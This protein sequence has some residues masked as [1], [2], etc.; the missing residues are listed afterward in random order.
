MAVNRYDIPAQSEF[1]NTYVPIPF[2]QMV[3][4]GQVQQQRYDTAS[5]AIDQKMADVAN[6]QAIPNSVDEDYVMGLRRNMQD[7]VDRYAEKDLGN[8]VVMRQINAEIRGIADP[9]RIKRI[10]DSYQGWTAR[11]KGAAQLSARGE[12]NE[13]LEGIRDPS[14]MGRYDS[15]TMGTYQYLPG[16]YEDPTQAMRTYFTDIQE[17]I[18]PVDEMSPE[19]QALSKEGYTIM[20][21]TEQDVDR[22]VEENWRDFARTVTGQNE[23]ELYKRQNPDWQEQGVTKEEV[24]KGML[25]DIGE[26]FYRQQPAGSRYPQ[27]K[28]G[29]PFTGGIV[30]IG[31]TESIQMPSINPTV[32]RDQLKDLQSRLAMMPEGSAER[33][34]VERSISESEDMLEFFEK[35]MAESQ[36][37]F[38]PAE[39]FSNYEKAGG[40][41]YGTVEKF[42][43]AVK[44]YSDQGRR[45]LGSQVI[46]DYQVPTKAE[47][48]FNKAIDEYSKRKKSFIEEGQFAINA[49]VITGTT[50]S[51]EWNTW[52]GKF[53]DQ[54]TKDVIRHS[55][56]F[57]RPFDNQ[58]L[59]VILEDKKYKN[60]DRTKD[61]VA[62]TD[63]V[64]DGNLQ[65]Q[66]SMF[67]EKGQ[68]L[69][70]EFV[71]PQG[72]RGQDDARRQLLMAANEMMNEGARYASL[73]GDPSL[74]QQG[75]QT[76]ANAWFRAD[77]QKSGFR[78]KVT[79]QLPVADPGRTNEPIRFE[80]EEGTTLDN[81]SYKLYIQNEDGTKDYYRNVSGDFVRVGGE[82]QL[83]AFLAQL[84]GV[85]Q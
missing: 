82:Q 63:A 49:N 15:S 2:E 35:Q 38:D 62:L 66:I 48:E 64:M 68:H 55:T 5:A 74:Y 42:E 11:T 17:R 31:E 73:T 36:H 57:T 51:K 84:Y 20:G 19:S 21:V 79:G 85:I 72:E 32:V 67:D 37:A 16:A 41:K 70:S 4:A 53:N 25:R 75:A 59:N 12:Y 78:N 6:L 7:I 47:S 60:R 27:G 24:V 33:A 43:E 22:V 50:G 81:P 71:A 29:S 10:Q 34:D 26:R 65:Y 69:G 54:I 45:E 56:G 83:A 28:T 46:Q 8:P 77:I 1:I 58:Q 61:Q 9:D 40:K 30:R 14:L 18:L 39:F 76:I 3:G 13:L 44:E 52:I 80:L 23:W